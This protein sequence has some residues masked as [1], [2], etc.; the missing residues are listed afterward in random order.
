MFNLR[1]KGLFLLLAELATYNVSADILLSET[2]DVKE[3]PNNWEVVSSE[4]ESIPNG[5]AFDDPSNVVQQL[6]LTSNLATVQTGTVKSELRLPALDFSNHKG[7]ILNFKQYL[8]R[9]DNSSITV[10]VSTDGGDSWS[11]IKG[12]SSDFTSLTLQSVDLSTIVSG[13]NNVK[14]AFVAE[15]PSKWF[16]DD[17]T[18]ETQTVPAIPTDLQ[19]SLG[20]NSTVNLTWQSTGENL[21]FVVERSD[22]SG[23]WQI[24]TPAPIKAT[25]FS[26]S[27]VAIKTT[28]Q[29]RV[30]ARNAAGNSDFTSPISI[31]TEGNS[32]AQGHKNVQVDLLVSYYDTYANTMSKKAAIEEN[33]KYMADAV[34]EMSNGAHRLGN[35]VIY[36]DGAKKDTADI[37]WNKEQMESGGKDESGKPIMELCS[38][39]AHEG[40]RIAERAPNKGIFH[41]DKGEQYDKTTLEDTKY[42]G[43]TLGHEFGH[44]FYKLLDEYKANQEGKGGF[45][46]IN[47]VPVKPSI[48]H[49]PDYAFTSS[50]TDERLEKEDYSW[51]NFSTAI[52]DTKQT[53]HHR[54][55]QE[56]A[57][58]TLIRDPK[59]DKGRSKHIE[60]WDRI[61]Y[62]EL[63]AVAPKAGEL[64]KL[65]LPQEQGTA[66]G[67]LKFIWKQGAHDQTTR[68]L[69]LG[70]QPASVIA[71]LDISKAVSKEQ[72]NTVKTA[73]KQWINDANVGDY[74]GVI[75]V[76]KTATVVQPLINIHSEAAKDTL[77]LAVENISTTSEEAN[78]SE[79]LKTALAELKSSPSSYSAAVYLLSAGENAKNSDP[80]K[81]IV[82]YQDQWIL[83]HTIGLS[84]NPTSTNLLSKLAEDT[85]GI[86]WQSNGSLEDVAWGL[87]EADQYTSPAINVMV[88]KDSKVIS[89][90]KT[91][92]FYIDEGIGRVN[93]DATYKGDIQNATLTL[94]YPDSSSFIFPTDYCFVTNEGNNKQTI[95]GVTVDYAPHGLWQ[96]KVKA[97]TTELDFNYH[98]QGVAKDNSKIIYASVE[99]TGSEKITF[100]Q[101]LIIS[102]AVGNEKPITDIAVSA[103]VEMPDGSKQPFVLRDDGVEPDGKASDGVYMGKI[104][105]VM[106]GL[107]K[108]LVHFNNTDNKANYSKLGLSYRPFPNG[109]SPPSPFTKVGIPFTRI[110]TAEINIQG[111]PPQLA[112]QSKATA[113]NGTSNNAF[114]TNQIQTTNGQAGNGIAISGNEKVRLA[115]VIIPD[116]KHVLQTVDILIAA[117]YQEMGSNQPIWFVRNGTN[118]EK[119]SNPIPSAYQVERIGNTHSVE[120]IEAP[121]ASLGLKGEMKVYVGYR[122]KDGTIIFNGSQPMQF[123]LK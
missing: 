61:Y 109:V 53:A 111:V 97:N 57:W 120:I 82:H 65:E 62:P 15:N 123:S 107:H 122:L 69:R 103:V 51:L 64:F 99:A 22:A 55:Y 112:V 66:R 102:A 75:S 92:S 113:S 117:S 47:D 77:N 54:V 88:T 59:T 96:L 48:M 26:D 17:V 89:G 27:N 30:A 16:I 73:V 108:L 52:N 118:W 28:Y 49:S 41:C 94:V 71:V 76:G 42:G 25:N 86:Y 8:V 14:I 70:N 121:L 72:L 50:E 9:T 29:Y 4:S 12:Y 63:Q 40:S 98:L 6:G 39:C 7:A 115:S 10:Q 13:K 5:W 3:K 36:T 68:R 11:T 85:Y 58:E 19:A 37:I 1:R 78:L 90:E 34:Y 114:F 81:E 60:G 21:E 119:L 35:V 67:G 2:F 31:T 45:P 33:F 56:S 91:F 74:V 101:P 20:R 93:F 38:F 79:G 18:I 83:L 46:D 32:T 95:C 110:A 44:Y 106:N 100:P 23:T 105:Y 87:D 84:D 43:Y 116:K 80:F 24:L 104:N